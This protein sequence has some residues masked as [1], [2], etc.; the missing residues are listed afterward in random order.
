MESKKG[1]VYFFRHIGLTPVKIGYSNNES[2]MNRFEQFKTYAPYGSELVGFIVCENSKELETIFHERFSFARL[3]GEWFEITDE[4]VE[5]VVSFYSN[6]EDIKEKNEFEIAWAKKKRESTEF[7]I[8][9]EEF[10]LIFNTKFSV[11][12]TASFNVK[13]VLS[14]KEMMSELGVTKKDLKRII[15]NYDL[16]YSSYRINGIVKRGFLLFSPYL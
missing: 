12:E 14:M 9:M 10:I 5:K 4:D 1:C 13:N 8:A 7:K 3:K 15:E 2:P 11:E 16:K 6:I